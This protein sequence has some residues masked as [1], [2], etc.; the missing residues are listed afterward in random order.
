[1]SSAANFYGI[2]SLSKSKMQNMSMTI[3]SFLSF[4]A[5]HNTENMGTTSEHTYDLMIL[6]LLKSL[7]VSRCR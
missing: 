2:S 4:F 1:V 3:F 6:R 5:K 7:Y